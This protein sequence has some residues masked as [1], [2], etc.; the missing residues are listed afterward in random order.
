MVTGGA[1]FHVTASAL[2]SPTNESAAAI[3]E[4]AA[5]A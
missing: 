3:T 1:A 2:T 4:V 5:A